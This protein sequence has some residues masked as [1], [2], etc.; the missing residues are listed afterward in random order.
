MRRR[1]VVPGRHADLVQR[2]RCRRR[3]HVDDDQQPGLRHLGDVPRDGG[4]PRGAMGEASGD[5]SERHPEGV[6]GPEGVDLSAGAVDA[7]R[8]GHV[9]VRLEARSRMEHDFDQRVSHPR[10]GRDRGPGTRVHPRE[11]HGVRP[12]GGRPRS[13]SRRLRAPP[14][15]FLQRPQRSLRGAREVPRGASHLGARDARHVRRQ[16]PSGLASAVPHPDGGREL[17][18]AATGD[19]HRPNDDPGARRS[20]RGHSVPPHKR[21]RRGV[22][23]SEREGR[24]NCAEDPADSRA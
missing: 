8:R 14:F 21:L 23:S 2:D 1:R 6:P 22:P 24:A 17:D 10:G 5:D 11:R 4:R 3:Q 7:A 13:E 12:L 18:R 20:P 15:V 9:R 19:E 16:G